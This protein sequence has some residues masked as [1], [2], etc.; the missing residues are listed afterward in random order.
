[1]STQKLREQANNIIEVYGQD[2]VAAEF[3]KE[4]ILFIDSQKT[5]YDPSKPFGEFTHPLVPS[6]IPDMHHNWSSK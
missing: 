6:T 5:W 3:A 4:V 2:T 1:M